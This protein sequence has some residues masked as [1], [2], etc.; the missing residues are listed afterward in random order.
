MSKKFGRHAAVGVVV[1]AASAAILSSLAVVMPQAG[2]GEIE[3]LETQPV[4]T[5]DL[6]EVVVS[7]RVA[8]SG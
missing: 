4:V 6:G 2:R 3:Y 5:G 7:T 8:Q 1:V